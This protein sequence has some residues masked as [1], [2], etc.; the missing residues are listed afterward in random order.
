MKI[1]ISDLQD[2]WGR[3]IEVPLR[4]D[5]PEAEIAGES[6]AFVKPL[7][8]TVTA[9]GAGNRIFVRVKAE[10]VGE[11]NCSRCLESFRMP[12]A[13]DFEEEYRPGQ[14]LP[15]REGEEQEEEDGKT[16]SVYQGDEIDLTEPIRQN[17]LLEIP[18][19]PV[20]RP[21]CKGLCPSC[22]KNW[23]EGP[24]ECEK[25]TGD[26]RFAVLRGLFDGKDKK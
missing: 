4:M 5:L 7:E 1:N 2:E 16:F 3:R 21:D 8:G 9:T 26:P 19:K 11:V 18:M 12:V 14:V 25:E 10:T 15:G 6:V 22:G 20:C 24:C 17:L 13:L 23:N